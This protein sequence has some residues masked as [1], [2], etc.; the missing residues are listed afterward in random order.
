[1][2]LCKTFRASPEELL[3]KWEAFLFRKESAS[4]LTTS[5]TASKKLKI[6]DAGALE[7]FKEELR[8]S[9][10]GVGVQRKQSTGGLTLTKDSIQS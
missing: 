10:S 5:G 1:V 9:M 8:R 3:T 4:T 2:S 6:D 7:E